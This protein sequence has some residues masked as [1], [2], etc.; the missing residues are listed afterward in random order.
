MIHDVV[1]VGGG[2]AGAACAYWLARAGLEV[3][4]LDNSHPRE[5]PCGGLISQDAFEHFP[6]LGDFSE[7]RPFRGQILLKVGGKELHY[8]PASRK[9][10]IYQALRSDL[11]LFFL[12]KAE[13]A[14]AAWIRMKAGSVRRHKEFWSVTGSERELRAGLIVGAEGTRS[15]VA[16]AVGQDLT[17]EDVVAVSGATMREEMPGA[18]EIEVREKWLGFV[19]PKPGRTDVGIASRLTHAVR[20]GKIL[21]GFAAGKGLIIEDGRKWFTM[22]P[23]LAVSGFRDRPISSEDWLLVG[24]AA[25]QCDPLTGEGIKYALWGAKIAADCIARGKPGEYQQLCSKAF[26]KRLSVSARVARGPIQMFITALE[27]FGSE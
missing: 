11:D 17:R 21:S 3:A 9:K 1:I 2:P 20:M 14:G 8:N 13:Q 22:M 12:D 27:L 6:P 10:K 16:K 5:K 4:V 19:I 24:D 26:M 15:L 25:G 23:S 7:I 18:I